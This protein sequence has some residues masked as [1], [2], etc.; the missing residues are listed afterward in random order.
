MVTWS[1]DRAGTNHERAYLIRS[2]DGGTLLQR[3]GRRV[4]AAATGPTSRPWPSRPTAATCTSIYNAYLTTGRPP[5]RRR[6][7]CSASSGTP[8]PTPTRSGSPLHRGAIGDAR[9]SSANGLTSEFLGDYNYAVATRTS[10]TLVWNDMRDGADCPAIDAYR[11]AFV[12]D[13]TGGPPSPIV[14]DETEDLEQAGEVP[15]A[16]SSEIR[17]APNNQCP[18]GSTIS[19]GN[20]SIYAITVAD[21]T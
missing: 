2:T 13:V 16:P 7:R 6:G 21:P 20:S 3:T 5:P 14:G 19:F 15:A 18:Q 1:D 10:A 9:G 8:T 12:N 11:Q 4:H 17:P